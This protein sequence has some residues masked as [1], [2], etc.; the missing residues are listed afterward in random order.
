M[1]QT[2][3]KCGEKLFIA[4]SKFVTEEGST[5]VYQELTLVCLN[6]RTDDNGNVLCPNF[7][8]PDLTKPRWS[9]PVRNKVSQ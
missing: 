1:A 9:M 5:E 8:G 3:P 6:Y 4:G 7:C 2:C